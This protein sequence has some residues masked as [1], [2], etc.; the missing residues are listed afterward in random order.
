MLRKKI[1]ELRVL[2]A[3]MAVSNDPGN[4]GAIHFVKRHHQLEQKN[5]PAPMQPG[6]DRP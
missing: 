5:G 3:I 6:L 1:F 4:T 2:K